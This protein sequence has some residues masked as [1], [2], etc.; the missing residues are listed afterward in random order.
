MYKTNEIPLGKMPLNV[1]LDAG[2]LRVGQKVL[3]RY[4]SEAGSQEKF[5]GYIQKNGIEV[6]GHTYSISYA[7]VY[8]VEK[9][10]DQRAVNGWMTW[11]TEDGRYLSEVYQD[12]LGVKTISRRSKKSTERF[13]HYPSQR[14]VVFVFGA[15]ASYADGAPLQKDILP[16]LL[17]TDDLEIRDSI[18]YRILCD[19]IEDNFAWDK[20]AGHYPTLEEVFGFLDYFI[21]KRESLNRKY[22]LGAI[23]EIKEALIKLT[24]CIVSST[25]SS[26]GNVYRLFWEAVYRYNTNISTI[27]LNYDTYLEDAF[28]HMFPRNMYLDYCINLSNYDHSDDID[29]KNWWVNPREPILSLDNL[30]PI[31]IKLIKIHGSLNWKYCNCCN[32]VLLT[33]LDKGIDLGISKADWQGCLTDNSD[34]ICASLSNARCS[35][36]EN[37]FQTMLVPPSHLKD[38][39]HPINSR[40]FIESAEE[41]RRARKVVFIGYSLPEADIHMKAILKKSLRPQTEIFVLNVDSSEKFKFR[42]KGLSKHVSFMSSSFEDFLNDEKMVEGIFSRSLKR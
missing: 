34:D 3:F 26:T 20:K 10:G 40:L 16:L 14:D 21:Q 8:C 38:L 2:Y 9:A 13:F 28:F 12:F 24:H 6:F 5:S 32:Q 30:E 37:E 29:D 39:S 15:G 18:L 4:L 19:F 7:A 25:T 27:T 11:Q 23:F 1:L 33:P 41:I 35:R 42:F 22:S 36:D 31:S 17:D